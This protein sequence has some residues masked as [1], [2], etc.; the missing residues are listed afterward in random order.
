MNRSLLVL[1]RRM[2]SKAAS[3]VVL[4]IFCLGFPGCGKP[5][6]EAPQGVTVADL[7][8]NFV[9]RAR[10]GDT[11]YF[12]PLLDSAA[13]SQTPEL[14]EM[15]KR[16]GM[17]TNYLG[18]LRKDSATQARLDYHDPD[19]QCHFQVDLQREGANWTVRRVYFCR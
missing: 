16:S 14:L 6:S 17:E 2:R 1:R 12:T 13:S 3:A 5:D 19:A 15:V 8:T 7:V 4:A 10:A 9:Q 11:T 18:R